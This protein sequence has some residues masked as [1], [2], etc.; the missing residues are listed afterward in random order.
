MRQYR[1]LTEAEWEYAAR[2]GS[3]SRYYWGDDIGVDNAN[4]GGC[5]GTRGPEI[6]A[7]GSL[8]PNK[9]DLYDMSGNVWQW[10]A[11]CYQSNYKNINNI[12][13]NSVIEECR[14]HVLRGG[15]YKNNPTAV[16]VAIRLNLKVDTTYDNIGF[17]VART[18]KP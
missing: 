1:L 9:F 17:R 6:A 12:S 10:V 14:N 3:R 4:C 2:A 7:A 16:R 5:R 11:D 13:T 15:S 8:R 18:L